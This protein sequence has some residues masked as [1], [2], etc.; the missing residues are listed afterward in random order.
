MT[1]Y[2]PGLKIRFNSAP[3]KQDA[4]TDVEPQHQQDNGCQASVHIGKIAEMRKIN[5]KGI[6]K[7]QPSDR[8]KDSSR[9][10]LPRFLLS[11][12]TMV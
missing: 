8:G 3:D 4:D 2:V 7:C 6:G 1:E 12:G 10:L 5:G 9:K 11:G